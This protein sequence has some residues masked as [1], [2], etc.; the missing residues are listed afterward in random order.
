VYVCGKIDA[1]NK[2]IGPYEFKTINSTQKI[3]EPKSYDVQQIKYYMTMTNS[4][5]GVLLYYHLDPKF[6]QDPSVK[7]PITMTEEELYSEHKKL[8]TSTL[9]L[10]KAISAE[11]NQLRKPN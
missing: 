5:N 4:T 2:E 11:N 1:F 7:F 3:R 6:V 8:V 10:S 9:S